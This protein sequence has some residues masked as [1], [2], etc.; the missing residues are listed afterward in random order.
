MDG[1]R[2]ALRYIYKNW[3]DPKEKLT[4][5][6]QLLYLFLLTLD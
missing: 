3:L 2:G 4:I 5:D 1:S 6:S